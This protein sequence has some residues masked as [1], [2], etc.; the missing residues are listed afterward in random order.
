MCSRKSPEVSGG[1]KQLSRLL[2]QAASLVTSK[3]PK[4]G[5]PLEGN[6][7]FS[8]YLSFFLRSPGKHEVMA[9]LNKLER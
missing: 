5:H 1:W 6:P 2:E 8:T 9:E 4:Q 7:T 3:V